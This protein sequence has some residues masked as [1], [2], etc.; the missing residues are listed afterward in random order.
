VYD[1]AATD[2]GWFRLTENDGCRSC[3]VVWRRE[4]D[5]GTWQ[6]LAEIS[7]REAY[8]GRIARDFGPLTTLVITSDG[9]HGWAWYKTLWSTHDG[10]DSWVRVTEGPGRATDAGYE[11]VLT[12]RHAWSLRDGELWRSPL[13][14]DAWTRIG[15]PGLQGAVDLLALPDR[16]VVQAYGE[17]LSNPRLMGSADG[18]YWSEVA[19]PCPGEIRPHAAGDTVFV[20]C[21]RGAERTVVHHSTGLGPWEVLGRVGTRFSTDLVALAEDRL[22]V[23]TGRTDSVLLTPDGAEGVDLG[24]R[25]PG[26]VFG[27]ESRDDVAYLL[28]ASGLLWSNDGGRSW[29]P[30]QE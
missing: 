24:P 10:G 14:R 13:E 30:P 25:Q 8:G 16:V 21:P 7:G 20:G 29:A 15:A 11:V 3:T 28:T 1:L 6:R 4:G 27:A 5:D 19:M 18:S 23:L 2:D 9:L 17:G 22:L 26:V 12:D